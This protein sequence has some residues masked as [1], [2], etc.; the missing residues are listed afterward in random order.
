MQAFTPKVQSWFDHYFKNNGHN[1]KPELIIGTDSSFS[2]GKTVFAVVVVIKANGHGGEYIYKNF[3]VTR[4][5]SLFEKIYSEVHASILVAKNLQQ[6]DIE[7]HIS[8]LT[9]HIDVNTNISAKSSKYLQSVFGMVKG[10][11][12]EAVAKPNAYAASHV[13][14]RH[15]R[16]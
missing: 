3:K 5:L 14:D 6:M 7:E 11:G 8:N 13:A 9:V 1:G 15:C 2:K 10:N 12:F 4:N 16:S